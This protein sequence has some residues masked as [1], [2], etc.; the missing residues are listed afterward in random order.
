MFFARLASF[1]VT[2]LRRIYLINPSQSATENLYFPGK[3][4]DGLSNGISLRK[5][6]WMVVELLNLENDPFLDGK[7]AGFG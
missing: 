4:D 6:Y 1:E 7:R 2:R 3:G 5:K